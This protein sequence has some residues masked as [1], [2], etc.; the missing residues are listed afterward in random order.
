MS[1]GRRFVDVR[2]ELVGEWSVQT[3][4]NATSRLRGGEVICRGHRLLGQRSAATDHASQHQCRHCWPQWQLTAVWAVQIRVARRREQTARLRRAPG[5]WLT[6]KPW[7]RVQFIA[8][9]ALQFLCNNC[10]WNHGITDIKER[11]RHITHLISLHPICL[12]RCCETRDQFLRCERPI[13]ANSHRPTR[14]TDRYGR[15]STY[16][17][18]RVWRV[19]GVNWPWRMKILM[20]KRNH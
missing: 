10:T 15:E 8:C 12:L 2:S 14:R 19:H 11:S 7:F 3:D 9:N 18:S 6:L 20:V 5:E 4:D 13:I 16:E 17:L 1:T